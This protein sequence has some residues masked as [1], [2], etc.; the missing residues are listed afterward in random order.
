[1]RRLALSGALS[2][3]WA[4]P[5]LAQPAGGPAPAAAQPAAAKSKDN[6]A[7]AKELFDAGAREYANGNFDLAIQALEQAYAISPREGIMFSMA[8]AHR[9]FYERAGDKQSLARSV[10]LYKQYVDKVKTGG[11]VTDAVK[12]LGQLE[13]ELK[14]ARETTGDGAEPPP[15]AAQPKKTRIVVNIFVEGTMVSIDGGAPK[16]PPLN[17]E[18]KPGPHKVKLFAPGYFEEEREIDVSEGEIAP[19]NLPQRERP[20]EL[21]IDTESGADINVDGRYIGEAPLSRPIE[22]PSGRHFVVV[23][24]NGHETWEKDVD[25]VRG[26]KHAFSAELSSTLQRDLSYAVLGTAGG[27]AAASIVFGALAFERDATASGLLD[28]RQA[29]GLSVAELADYEDAK[30]ARGLYTGVAIG[31]AGGG[32]A[33]AILG[34]GLLVFD[35]PR[36]VAAPSL[37]SPSKPSGPTPGGEVPGGD[38][39]GDIEMTTSS[40]DVGPGYVGGRLGFSF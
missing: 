24:E 22:L 16:K 40:L 21:V 32:V 8:Q 35:K 20:A 33:L 11:R 12:A 31:T 38:E 25:L 34:T 5:V 28:D 7:R 13:P 23:L 9:R 39:P 1:M 6:V 27:F 15:I 36:A 26:K 10:E 30:K 3:I 14:K 4:T 2:V 37:E 18:V 17:E 19:A 29:R